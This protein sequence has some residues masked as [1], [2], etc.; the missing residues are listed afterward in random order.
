MTSQPPLSLTSD[1]TSLAKIQILLVPVHLS[2]SNSKSTS[3]ATET[4]VLTEAIY[5]HWA[6]LIKRHQTLRGDEIRRPSSQ[7]SASSHSRDGAFPDN[8]KHR[9]FPSTSNSGQS[10]SRG[11][12]AGPGTT[13]SSG[14]R[15][16]S[17]SQHVHVTYPSHPPARH[18]YPLSLLR[19]A[20]FPLVVIGI[21]VDT[22]YGAHHAGPS[23]SPL[24]NQS[25][26]GYAVAEEN[27]EDAGD[28]GEAS[29]PVAPTFREIPPRSKARVSPTAVFEQTL[30]TL[31]PDTSPFPLVRRLI[32][33]PPELP[34]SSN[35]R[36]GDRST[37]RPNADRDKRR[38]EGEVLRAPEDGGDSWIGKVMGEVIGDVLGELGEIVSQPCRAGLTTGDIARVVFWP[39][40]PCFNAV[41]FSDRLNGASARCSH[42]RRSSI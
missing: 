3:V 21:A 29:T 19:M 7:S 12:E 8:A 42:V 36:N 37:P 40:H 15:G 28:I 17:Q 4:P 11:G 32:V 10:V 30:S 39:E 2:S 26:K 20:G 6:S 16:P 25:V 9:F 41:A 35:T 38:D 18:L 24:N 34:S 5:R 1:P 22:D 23:S 31:F 27:E 14:G 33:V 13:S